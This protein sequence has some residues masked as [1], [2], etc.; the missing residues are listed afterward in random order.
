MDATIFAYVDLSEALSLETVTHSNPSHISIDTLYE[1]KGKIPEAF[2]RGAGVP[3]IF[4]QYLPSLVN[5]QYAIQFYSCFISYSHKDEA[6]AK[7]LY[8]RLQQEHVRVWRAAE[9]MKAGEKIHEQIDKA[10]LS[11][12]KLLIVLSEESMKSEWVMTEIRKARNAEIREKRRKL[13]PIRLVDFETI[14]AWSCFDSDNGKDLAVEVREYLIPDFSNWKNH[15]SFEQGFAK[16]LADLKAND[17]G[18][19]K[20][21]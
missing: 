14:K 2:L 19:K 13:F 3:D 20:H 17:A 8:E 10:I 5:A 9:D 4:I 18:G 1:S 11:Y 15:D 21:A 6:F 12:D 7:L 16:L